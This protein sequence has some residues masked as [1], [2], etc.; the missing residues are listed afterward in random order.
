M[1]KNLSRLILVS[2]LIALFVLPSVIFVSAQ[3]EEVSELL[4][5]PD[6]VVTLIETLTNWFFTIL[7]AIAVIF[8]ILAAWT[9]LTAGG[10]PESV[11]KARQMLIYAL[12]GIAV[13]ILAK[14]MPAIIKSILGA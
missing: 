7:L 2:S 3:G 9:F 12:I 11:T 6:E 1:K 4:S 10:N 5:S 14:S 8:I 13:A